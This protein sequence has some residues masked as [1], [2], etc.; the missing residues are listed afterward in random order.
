MPVYDFNKPEDV[1]R[2]WKSLPNSN[3]NICR[4]NRVRWWRRF[5]KDHGDEFMKQVYKIVKNTVAE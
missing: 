5:Q 4:N 1:A 3:D 2:Y